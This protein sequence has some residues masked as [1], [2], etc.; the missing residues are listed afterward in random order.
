MS[1]FIVIEGADGSGKE[2]QFRLTNE[3]LKAVGHDVVTFDFPRYEKSS[4]H[5]VKSYLNGDYGPASEISPYTA[6]MFYAL[7]RYEAAPQIREALKADKIVLANRYVG[8]NMAHQGAKFGSLGQQRGFFIWADSLEF[9]LLGIPRPTINI[10]LRVPPEISY[11]LITQKGARSYTDKQ[12][13]QHEADLDHIRKAVTTYDLL[14]KLFPKDFRAVECAHNGQIMN[15][16]EINDRIWDIVKP[17]LPEPSRK[18]KGVVLNLSSH[19]DSSLASTS[20]SQKNRSGFSLLAADTI[21][22]MSETTPSS[23]EAWS[24]LESRDKL[25]FY[26]P[27]ELRGRLRKEY[28]KG[29]QEILNLYLKMHR[30]VSGL[31]KNIN[32]SELYAALASVIPLGVLVESQIAPNVLANP[33]LMAKLASSDITEVKAL[34]EPGTA[35]NE[36]RAVEEI[37]K[38]LAETRLPQNLADADETVKLLE[39]RPRN[40]F[41]LLIESMYPYSNLSRAEIAAQIDIWTYAQKQAA[42]KTALN[43]YPDSILELTSYRFDVLSD[44]LTL[45]HMLKNN[46][47]KAIHAQNVTPRYGYEVPEIIEQTQLDDDFLEAFDHSLEL[48]NRL[49]SAGKESIGAYTILLG[50]KTRWQF[51]VTGAQ[52]AL[53]VKEKW[54]VKYRHFSQLLIE[55][56]SELH[57]HIARALMQSSASKKQATLKSKPEVVK[58]KKSTT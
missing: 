34:A 58:V 25:K 5:F 31:A 7:D 20:P 19:D 49:Q 24:S 53:S 57:P 51:S 14:C 43:K 9:E 41:E 44:R 26:T 17:L 15:I 55:A 22:A 35:D 37:I 11:T 6:S 50:H 45:R 12:R 56:V 38:R 2:T 29:M 32:K 27:N 39:P 13:D 4:S 3:R 54:P 21:A 52:L 16:T 18:G 47:A 30:R 48:Y 10:F 33:S 8:S 36:P 28:Q 46:L 42:L 40:E 1:L 23:S